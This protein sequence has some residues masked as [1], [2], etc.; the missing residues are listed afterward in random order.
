MSSLAKCLF[1]FSTHFLIGLFVSLTLNFMSCLCILKIDPLLVASFA[2]ICFH[3]EG[4]LFNSFMV[5]FAVRKLLSLML[6]GDPDGS[7]EWGLCGRE[8]QEGGEICIHIADSVCCTAETNT[9]L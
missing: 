7:N 1:R 4:C 5:F 8:T 2:N 9:T 3:S 6:C